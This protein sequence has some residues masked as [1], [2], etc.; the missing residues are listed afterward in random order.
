MLQLLDRAGVLLLLLEELL[1]LGAKK[2]D[3]L[4]GLLE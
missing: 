2:I 1:T 4:R 3:F